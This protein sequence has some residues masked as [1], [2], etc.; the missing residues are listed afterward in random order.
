MCNY[1]CMYTH[2]YSV[3]VA[4]NIEE[5]LWRMCM[6]KAIKHAQLWHLLAHHRKN[7][8]AHNLRQPCLAAFLQNAS[9]I[10]THGSIHVYVPNGSTRFTWIQIRV[11]Y[12]HICVQPIACVLLLISTCVLLLISTCVLLLTSTCVLLLISTCVDCGYDFNRSYMGIESWKFL[13]RI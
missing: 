2:M 3:C 11:H 10:L 12:T 4:T 5:Q 8:C 1:W 9:M 6:H 13:V 7:V